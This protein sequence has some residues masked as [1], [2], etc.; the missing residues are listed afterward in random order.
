MKRREF[1]GIIG[2]AI[3]I[4][5]AARAQQPANGKLK[6]I[7]IVHP[8]IKTADLSNSLSLTSE[9]SG[10]QAL[11]DELRHLGYIEGRNIVVERYS[12]EGLSE[13]YA[14][15]ARDVVRTNPDVILAI[16]T[17]L[18]LAFKSATATIPLVTVTSDPIRAGLVQSIARPGGNITGITG[19]TG[20][21]I[22]GKRLGLLR[23][24]AP[25]IANIRFLATR[26]SWEG[27]FGEAVREAAQQV[28]IPLA[29]TL[30]ERSDEAEYLRVLAAIEQDRVDG[31]V[32]SDSADHFPFRQLIVEWAARNRI[33]A[34]YSLRY[35]VELGG[36]MAYSFDLSDMWRGAADQ[37]D[38]IIKGA[39][40]GDIPYYQ[41]THFEFTINLRTA[42][43]LG[44]ELPATL[45]ARADEVIE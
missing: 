38:K 22:W 31:L 36:L 44:L 3:A 10:Y 20:S 13:R 23:E 28:R 27:P 40:P 14:D 32:V 7:A 16:T 18:S 17:G 9:H 21:E 4:P 1:F 19:D 5:L 15:L 29:A 42:R 41:P 39:N 43:T 24:A 35:F 25:N 8:S 6:R 26:I 45:V 33:P 2:G 12:S 34:I 30:V 11:F 37:I